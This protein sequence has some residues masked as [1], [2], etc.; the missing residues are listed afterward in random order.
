MKKHTE[1]IQGG[2]DLQLER[3]RGM[4]V[5]AATIHAVYVMLHA[6]LT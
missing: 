3:N 4:S 2:D 6:I 5:V 1:L